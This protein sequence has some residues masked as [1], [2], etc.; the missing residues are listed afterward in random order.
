[1]EVRFPDID[2]QRQIAEVLER[3]D[4]LIENNRRRI[5]L[6]EESARLLYREWFVH[7]RFPGWAEVPVENGKPVTWKQ[8]TFAEVVDAV[9]GATPS[10]T[11]P[12]FWDG[13]V[14]WLTPTDVT[15]N[16]CLYL[17]TSSR[18]ISQAGYD[19]CSAT[20]MPAG[21][22]FMTSRASIG[23]FAL[24]DQPACTN[25]GFISVV[26][27]LPHS[28][29]FFLF[30]LMSR[31]EEFEAKA[32]GATFKELSKKAFRDLTVLVPDGEVLAAFETAVQPLV[33]QVINLKKQTVRLTEARDALL[34]KLMSG[35]IAV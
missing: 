19:A 1:V 11:R 12:D 24:M 10:T 34:P 6:L 13:E 7:L 25:Q 8:C 32:T 21:T 27:K 15:R 30:H 4:D 14:I 17:P 5:A 3:Y 31:V 33:D 20:L 16:D 22:I 35:E 23:Y 29:N 26:P 9:G 18:K 2:S 28:R